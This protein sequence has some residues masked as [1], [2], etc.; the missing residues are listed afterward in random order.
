[1][2]NSHRHYYL[3]QYLV[4]KIDY[5]LRYGHKFSHISKMTLT[6]LTN[7]KNITYEYF[8]KQPKSMIEWRL[9]EKLGRNPKLI[10][11]IDRTLSNPLIREYSNVDTVENQDQK[12]ELMI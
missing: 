1:M 11:A 4:T 7:F 2:Y 6:F 5:F 9:I 10:K 8:L 12:M 3:R